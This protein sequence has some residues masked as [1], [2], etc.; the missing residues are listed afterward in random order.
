MATFAALGSRLAPV[1]VSHFDGVLLTQL[2]HQRG[3]AWAKELFLVIDPAPPPPVL[4]QDAIIAVIHTSTAKCYG[5]FA[6]VASFT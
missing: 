5:Q 3:L 6:S 2:A 4:I 1:D